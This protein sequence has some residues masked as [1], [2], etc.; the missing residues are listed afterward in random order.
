MGRKVRERERESGGKV[1]EKR[2][3]EREERVVV[4][5]GG[6]GGG[7]CWNIYR[8]QRTKEM[9]ENSVCLYMCVRQ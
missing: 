1:R 5:V 8:V 6:G 3:R 9:K 7:V 4:V 2:K